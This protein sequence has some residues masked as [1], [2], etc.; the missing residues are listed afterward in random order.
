M[1]LPSSVERNMARRAQI[2]VNNYSQKDNLTSHHCP[3]PHL[4]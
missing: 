3:G 1:M 4:L 2:A